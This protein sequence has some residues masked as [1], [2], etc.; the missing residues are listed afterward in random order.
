MRLQSKMI[1]I[2]CT[3]LFF[4]ISI[5]GGIFEYI[6][7]ST[8]KEQIGNRALVVAQTVASIPTIRSAF[9]EDQPSTK[10]QPITEEIRLKTGA[11]F[12]VVGNR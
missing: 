12:I 9:D 11:E 3:L 2:I 10:I 7:Y 6:G 5:L 8:I 4:V 1:L